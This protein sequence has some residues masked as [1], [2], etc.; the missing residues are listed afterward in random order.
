MISLSC[1]LKLFKEKVGKTEYDAINPEE[2]IPPVH[3]I[4]NWI[5]LPPL[6]PI[7]VTALPPTKEFQEQF[8]T[9]IKRGTKDN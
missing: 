9:D 4:T 6:K 7:N 5:N 3:D 2:Y 8:L 1:R